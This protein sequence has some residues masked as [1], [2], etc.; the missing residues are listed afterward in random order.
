[1][2]AV[3]CKDKILSVAERPDPVPG[4][5]RLVRRLGC[6]PSAGLI[7]GDEGLQPGFETIDARQAFVD[8]ID[9]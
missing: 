4:T 7:D 6:Q 3:V 8:Q 1:M 9:R 2:K 5:D